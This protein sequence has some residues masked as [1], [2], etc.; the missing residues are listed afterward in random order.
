MQFP[1]VNGFIICLMSLHTYIGGYKTATIVL[2]VLFG[3]VSLILIAIGV[4][5]LLYKCYPCQWYNDYKKV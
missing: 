2:G 3:F 4:F 5:V 1:I